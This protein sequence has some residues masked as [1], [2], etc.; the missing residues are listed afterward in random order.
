VRL[1]LLVGLGGGGILTSVVS[2]GAVAPVMV[3][4]VVSV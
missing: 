1:R 4:G 2:T 3:V